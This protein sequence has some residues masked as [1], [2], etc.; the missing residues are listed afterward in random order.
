MASTIARSRQR[1]HAPSNSSTSAGSKIVGNVR[2]VRTS[3]VPRSVR[4]RFRFDSPRGTGFASTSP[5]ANKNPNRPEIDD[6]RRWIV[7]AD[8]PDSPSV[9]RTTPR[10]PRCS[11]MKPNT[12][13]VVTSTGSFATLEKKTF[14]S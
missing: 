11:V 2:G 7:R 13:D 4:D 1:R 10:S 8:N 5:H 3:G 9:K 12:S 14:R 6:S